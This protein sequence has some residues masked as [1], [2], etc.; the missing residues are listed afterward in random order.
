[1]AAAYCSTTRCMNRA[2]A[3]SNFCKTHIGTNTNCGTETVII[4]KEPSAFDF[5]DG[6]IIGAALQKESESNSNC[7]A[8]FVTCITINH[9]CNG[10]ECC[11]ENCCECCEDCGE[12]DGCDD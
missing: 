5:T 10:C 3:N 2:E 7:C 8:S 12:C 1:M 9:C 4:T 11:D 6:I